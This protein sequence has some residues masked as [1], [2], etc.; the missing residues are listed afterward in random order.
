MSRRRG[1]AV[2]F[3]TDVSLLEPPAA[4]P[5]LGP[6]VFNLVFDGRPRRIDLSELPCPRLVRPLARELADIGGQDGTVREWSGFHQMVRHL[7]AFL[8][9]AATAEP[10]LADELGLDDLEPELL[11]AWETKLAAEYGPDSGE[12]H[13]ALRTVVRLLR[14]ADQTRPDALSAPMQARVGFA[15]RHTF[16]PRPQPLDAY[17]LP[18]FEAIQAAALADVR[19]IRDR[20][21]AGERLAA[22]GANPQ[23]EGWARLEN[24]LWHIARYGP[25]TS[26][27]RRV[28]PVRSRPGGVG[29]FN[30][31]LLLTAADLVPFVVLLI[32]QTGLEPECAKGLRADCLVNPAR[33]F[34]SIAYVKKRARND[35]HKTIRVSDGGALHFPGGLIRLAL[36]LTARGRDLTGGDA[37]WTDVRRDGVHTSFGTGGSFGRRITEWATRNGLD[38]LT[39]RG[40]DPVRLDLRRLRKTY[41]SRRYLQAAGV[42]D[43]FTAGHSPQVAAAHYADIDA[44]RELHEQAIEAGLTQALE[45]ALPPPVVA[46]EHGCPLD[47]DTPA[48]TPAQVSAAM[49]EQSDVFLASCTDFYAS[50]FART[51]GTGCPVAIWGCLECSNAVY[52]TRHL[53]SL[54]AFTDFLDAQREDL[55]EA[56]WRARYGLAFDRITTAITPKFTTEQIITARLIAEANGQHL[57]IPAQILEHIT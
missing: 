26:E 22:E 55:P 2:R 3:P 41:K 12:P 31:H 23:V 14:L 29:G 1:R 27:Y 6:I 28:R 30:E 43:D 42:L 57:S 45:V 39:D 32:C 24:V 11:D 40:G 8:D 33:G 52:T 4:V 5:T 46:D 9:F 44:H 25:L 48:L 38:T 19:A 20:I 7:R 15:T 35:A 50:P 51:K 54:L 18:V 56:E 37:L 16:Q 17:P 36:R 13:A 21:A 47:T 49:S 10:G 34:V 53:P